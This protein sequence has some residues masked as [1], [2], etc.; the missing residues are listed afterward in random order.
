[1]S[2]SE[3]EYEIEFPVFNSIPQAL[4][5]YDQWVNWDIDIKEGGTVS[6]VQ[7]G[8]PE[9]L[10]PAY[11]RAIDTGTGLGFLLTA[12]D[13]FAV[14]E[15]SYAFDVESHKPRPWAFAIMQELSS[16]AE[17]DGSTLRIFMI[18]RAE[19]HCKGNIAIYSSDAIIPVTGHVIGSYL[20]VQNCQVEI[21][22]FMEKHLA[23]T[24]TDYANELEQNGLLDKD[25][26]GFLLDRLFQ[27]DMWHEQPDIFPFIAKCWAYPDLK[28]RIHG[29]LQ[30]W[31]KDRLNSFMACLGAELPKPTKEKRQVS[32]GGSERIG[33]SREV[34]L[35]SIL[36]IDTRGKAKETFYNMSMILQYHPAWRDK[37]RFDSFLNISL[38]EDSPVTDVTEMRIAEWMG[39]QYGFG[40]NNPKTL[41][42]AVHAASSVCTYDSLQEWVYALPGWD[43]NHRLKTWMVKCCGSPDEVTTAWIGYV[44]IM[45]MIARAQTP[46]CMA[47]LVP[48]W[49]GPENKGKTSAIMILG[50]PWA[51][52][53]DMSM[54]SKEAHMAIQGCWVAE[55]SE[56]DALR[57]TTE[58]RL[59]SFISQV[60]DSYVPK[61]A[62]YRVDHPRRTVF[63][64]TTNED[65]Y[66]QGETGNTRWLPIRTES[67]DLN[68]LRACR[69][70]LF[71]EA[72]AIFNA[73]PDIEWWEEPPI[74]REAIAA[75]RDQR[76]IL[77][78]YEDDLKDWLDGKPI[79]RKKKYDYEGRLI[80]EPTPE[81]YDEVTWPDI[82]ERYFQFESREKWGNK[83]VQAQVGSALQALGWRRGRVTRQEGDEVK[84]VKC[85]KRPA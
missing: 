12:D 23:P 33:E 78:V 29:K 25:T 9:P 18:G 59:K 72:I 64:G 31:R 34:D 36:Q 13:P 47:R 63:F 30:M 21:D 71:A 28:L 16:Y 61:Y 84:R 27:D 68:K 50:E 14:A 62:N 57:K 58:T 56:L 7:V 10:R 24:V 79:S 3:S 66:F 43:G 53:F 20:D 1:M 2:I 70:Q 51:M 65:S 52:T 83:V 69:D 75:A 73:T 67:F 38:L 35:E 32:D 55:L 19:N 76:R 74:V 17:V 39:E 54:D 77:N 26:L 80:D 5:V 22:V 49:E 11:E 82:A 15:L 44:T 46:G 37:L 60:K 42:R 48:V 40:G 4:A 8:E 85:W 6:I 41:T 45:Q 81:K